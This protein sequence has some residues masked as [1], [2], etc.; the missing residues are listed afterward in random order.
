MLRV[1][2]SFIFEGTETALAGASEI[3]E[4]RAAE[5]ARIV[6]LVASTSDILALHSF[7]LL[8]EGLQ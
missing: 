8:T 1:A 2:C 3:I 5:I 7:Y 6:A 4:R